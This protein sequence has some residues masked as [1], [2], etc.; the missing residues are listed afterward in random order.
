M[1]Q[2]LFILSPPRSFTTITC[3]MLG[4]HPQMFGLAETNLFYA[5][6]VRELNRLYF[7]R[8]TACHG[9]LR[10][11][12]ELGFQEQSEET[13]EAA[14]AWLDDNGDSSTGEL[15]SLLAEWAPDRTL[16]DKSPLHV[17]Q[18]DRLRRM[19]DVFPHAYFLHL[20]RHPYTMGK[21]LKGLR[22]RVGS[23]RGKMRDRSRRAGGD[24]MRIRSSP[25]GYWLKPH[26]TILEF[27]ERVA[28]GRQMRLRGEDLLSDP[29]K[30]LVQICEWLGKT[31]SQAAI[32]AMLHP[33]R[34]PFAKYG[35]SNAMFGNDPNYMEKPQL[36][37]YTEK[38]PP[39]EDGDK[40]EDGTY[41]S[42]TLRS[43][44]KAL[45]Y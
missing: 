23:A 39:I 16:I 26:L 1:Q 20:T 10:S 22:E 30:Y 24:E 41:Y 11:I 3:A 35:P 25:D 2:P 14:K 34:S 8:P 5:D 28:P 38:L 15:F 45:G 13:I 31:K 21:S 42:A 36:R 37:T 6:R 44:A 27:L 12:A 7:A 17:F 43:Y 9:L 33:E 4:C 40:A 18:P 19:L 29:P 32:E